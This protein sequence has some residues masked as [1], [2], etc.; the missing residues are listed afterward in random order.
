VLDGLVESWASYWPGA[1]VASMRRDVEA[2]V[3]AAIARWDL[4]EPTPVTGGNVSVVLAGRSPTGEDVVLKVNPRG[5]AEDGAPAAQV[6]A[7]RAWGLDGLAPQVHDVA[8]DG[9]TVLMERIVPGTTLDDAGTRDEVLAVIAALTRRLH[10]SGAVADGLATLR[11]IAAEW[12][13][14]LVGAG[15]VDDAALLDRLLATAPDPVVLHA[16]LHGANVLRRADGGWAVVDPHAVLGDP[17][18][19][20]WILLDPRSLVVSRDAARTFARA[21]GLDEE[22][23]LAWTR[24]RARAEALE[25]ADA[26]EE[27][28]ARLHAT[29]DGL[30]G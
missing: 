25:V 2:R 28:A 3:A 7:L 5:H 15:R 8:D 23:A 14:T 16:D 10:A 22:R 6:L 21:A 26:D 13:R 17:A 4:A 18:A 9:Q 29:A 12:R 11:E 1:D 30:T 19:E 20:T 27:W 24:V